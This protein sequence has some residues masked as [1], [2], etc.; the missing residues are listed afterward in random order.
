MLLLFRHVALLFETLVLDGKFATY[1]HISLKKIFLFLSLK[2]FK[3][4]LRFEWFKFV[5][6]LNRRHVTYFTEI[7]Y[8][9]LY[10]RY[11]RTFL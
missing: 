11:I 1:T 2:S 8:A 7:T 10:I 3:N 9:L 4:F 5:M 6:S